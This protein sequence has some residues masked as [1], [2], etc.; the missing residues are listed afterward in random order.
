MNLKN[1]KIEKKRVYDELSLEDINDRR[2]FGGKP[3]GIINF[4]KV[5]YQWAYEIYDV[6]LNNT[7]FP[8]E[9]A[10]NNEKRDYGMLSVAEKRMYDLVLSQLIFMDSLQTNNLMD[11]INPY[12]TAPEVNSCLSRQSFEESLHSKSYQVL[13]D[14]ISENTDEIYDMWRTD[15]KLSEKNSFIA[16]IYIE[17]SSGEIT[18]EKLL[19]ALFA[20]QILEGIYFYAGFAA[21]YALGKSGKMLGTSQM[22]RFIQRDEIAHLLLFQN[23]INSVRKERPY[24][25]T[26]ELE[27]KVR[28]MF[29]R[30]VELEASWGIYITQGQIL[31]F[32]DAIITQYIQY[33]AD[34][35]LEAVG[36][37]PEYNVKHP[38]PW[39]D[40]Y[41]S[42]NDQRS[43]FFEG[44]V[45]NYSKGSISFDDDF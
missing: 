29:R 32:T 6:M 34:R 25:F 9:V 27:Q 41:A 44:K 12:I 30:A 28:T 37:K 18:D 40:G 10:V 35:R 14:S 3:T 33:L 38:I 45:L 23:M 19:L 11:N 21:M 26:Q 8:A 17:L 42:F 15:K 16:S 7:W 20:N 31:G 2:I 24:L 36:Y 4:S 39:V 13:A 1:I 22:I 43:N 5:K